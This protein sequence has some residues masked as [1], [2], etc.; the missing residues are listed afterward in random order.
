MTTDDDADRAA[1]NHIPSQEEM[2]EALNQFFD[3]CESDFTLQNLNAAWVKIPILPINNPRP[4]TVDEGIEAE[5]LPRLPVD[6]DTGSG[7]RSNSVFAV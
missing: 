2:D 7:S 5:F 4:R 3:K 6:M 1:G